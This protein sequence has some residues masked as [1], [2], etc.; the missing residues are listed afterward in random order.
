LEYAINV[1]EDLLVPEAQNLIALPFEIFSATLIGLPFVRLTM[2]ATVK[3]DNETCFGTEEIR[4]VR[5]NRVL[6]PE[7]GTIKLTIP[8]PVP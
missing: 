6:P 4:D 1:V 5:T 7:F 2:L 8:Q 3:L